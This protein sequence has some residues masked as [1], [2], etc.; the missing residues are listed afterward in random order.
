MSTPPEADLVERAAHL[1]ESEHTAADPLPAPPIAARI[2]SLV[3]RVGDALSWIWLVLLGV[4]VLN[5]VLRYVFASGR[6]EFEELQW[7]LYAV[8][9]LVGLS[10]CVPS[11]SHIRVDFLRDRMT[12]RIRAWIELYGLLLLVAPFVLL[13]LA[14]SFPFVA[15]AWRTGE[16]SAA[17][18]GLPARWL[19]KAALPIGMALLGVAVLARI[20]RV[21]ALLFGASQTPADGDR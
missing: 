4:I 8:G 19:I 13:V 16:V 7:H 18:G 5:V 11:D 9:F 2:E 1:A 17:A 15:E 12:P 6:I 10:Y 21:G 14:S 20:A 3:R